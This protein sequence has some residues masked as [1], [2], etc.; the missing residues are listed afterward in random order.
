MAGR[1]PLFTDENVQGTLVKALRRNGWELVRA[2]D[3]FP[4]GTDDEVQFEH[5]AEQGWILVTNDEPL[6]EIANRWLSEGRSF[7]GLIKWPQRHHQRMSI[8][9]VVVKF[10][11][12]AEQD[13]P[14]PPSYPIVH[15]KPE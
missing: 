14:F 10:E 5:A 13:E 1:F 4:Q 11:V 8:G 3:V 9:D 6:E 12:L 15:I 7:P 2:V